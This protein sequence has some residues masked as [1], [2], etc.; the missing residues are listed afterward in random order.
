MG[1]ENTRINVVKKWD[2]E[3]FNL[4]EISVN[5]K[6]SRDFSDLEKNGP[7]WCSH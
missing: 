6:D 4:S 5:G 2:D 1:A 3:C 7:K